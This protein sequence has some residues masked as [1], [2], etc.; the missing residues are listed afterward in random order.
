M[1]LAFGAGEI[2]TS[3]KVKSQKTCHSKILYFV[4]LLDI[5]CMLIAGDKNI[6]VKL[7][8]CLNQIRNGNWPKGPFPA[9]NLFR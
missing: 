4:I 7:I 3:L 6:A 8:C 1:N 5:R 9:V 2:V